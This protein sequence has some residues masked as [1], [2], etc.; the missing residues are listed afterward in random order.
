MAGG[1]P[2]GAAARGEEDGDAGD[3]KRLR[4]ALDDGV[5]Q[6]AEVGLG[7]QAAA[8]LDQ[9]LAIVVALAVENAVNALLDGALDGIEERRGDDDGGDQ[10]VETRARQPG[11]DQRGSDGHQ[12]EVKAEQGSGGQGVGDAALEDEV[13][14]HEAIADDRPGKRE[15]QHH[16]Q[17]QSQ[18]ADQVGDGDVREEGDDV[19]KG[20]RGHGHEGAAGEPLEL[21]AAERHLGA[22]VVQVEHDRGEHVVEVEVGEGRLLETMGEQPGGRP[23]L[24]GVDLQADNAAGGQVGE[25]DQ[26]L[27][28]AAAAVSFIRKGLR[29]VQEESRLQRAG[30]DVAPVHHLVEQ[31]ELARVEERVHHEGREAKDVEVQRVGRGPAAEEDIEADAEV[32]QRD[33]PE[34]GI[35][36]AVRGFQDDGNIDAEAVPGDDVVRGAVN[37][38]AEELADQR[39]NARDFLLVDRE[40][41]IA[42]LDAGALARAVD[43]NPLSH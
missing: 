23:G 42:L 40:Q 36:A 34:A 27:I 18:V 21:L 32:D 11:V 16:Q 33:Q 1:E 22:P 24:E 41:Q 43:R 19:D 25:G 4:Q 13:D 15:R 3:Q 6:V 20:E 30:D 37:L 26:D 29:E 14:V 8:K 28:L 5:E 31:V 17:D 35:D 2:V 38:G 9:R 12:E 10:T 39:S 7:A